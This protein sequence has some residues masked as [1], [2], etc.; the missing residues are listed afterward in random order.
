M[1]KITIQIQNEVQNQ[2]KR[3]WVTPDIE[4]ISTD[5]IQGGGIPVF[6]ESTTFVG[7]QDS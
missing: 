1:E 7:G 5:D 2:V 3:A 4:V 6:F